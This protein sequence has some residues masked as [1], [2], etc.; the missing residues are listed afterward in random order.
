M[1]SATGSGFGADM[2]QEVLKR[3]LVEQAQLAQQQQF[4]QKLAE[5]SRQANMS[6]DVAKGGLT[7]GNR[8]VDEDARQF[9]EQAPTRIALIGRTNAETG[10]LQRKPQAEQQQRAFTLSRDTSNQAFQSGR[11]QA[12][13]GYR[14]GEIGAEGAQRMREIGAQGANALAVKGSA[15]SPQQQNEVLDSIN[16]IDQISNDPAL[17]SAVGPVDQYIGQVHDLEGVNRFN[18]LHNQLVGKLSLAQAGK[19]KGQGQISDKERAMLAAAATAL[20]KGLS[21]GDYKAE[22]GKI[23]GQFERMSNPGAP[24]QAAPGGGT[25][26]ARDP[27]GNLHEAPAG[28]PLPAGW[29][30]EG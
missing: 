26:R 22:L 1:A 23:R 9:N 30:R 11:D 17:A 7:L 27:Q 28:T 24:A 8:R 5:D 4:A 6:N 3:K 13:H 10:E 16:L 15:A 12:Q 29:K 20:T 25:I 21:E 18:A 19:L 14:I 2:L